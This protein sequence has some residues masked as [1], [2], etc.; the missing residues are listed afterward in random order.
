MRLAAALC[1]LAV[2]LTARAQEP[3]FV[4]P[5]VTLYQHGGVVGLDVERHGDV[6]AV[7]GE[8]AFGM[9]PPWTLSLRALT[10]DAPGG[11]P[12]FAR[13]HLGARLRLLKRD[14]PREWLILSAYGAGALPAGHTA[15]AVADA[16]GVPDALVGLSA[17]RMARGGDAFVDL[18]LAQVPTPA[19]TAVAA[20]AL[21]LAAGWRPKPGGYGDLEV[22][23]FGE[24]LLQYQEGGVA[25]LGAAPGLLLHSRN[26]A[27]KLGL[28]VP[29]WE[30]GRD[31]EPVV[32]AAAKLLF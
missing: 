31:A 13:M 32:R 15:D 20:G 2:P 28:L 18:S 7:S 21:G 14:R 6:T 1:L 29:L 17:T 26:K 23:L 9:L 24:A 30:R 27:I 4:T 5:P 19:G 10:I 12:E 22:Q 3:V 16:H 11:S 25:A 8:V